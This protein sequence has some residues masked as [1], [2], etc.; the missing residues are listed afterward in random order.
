MTQAEFNDFMATWLTENGGTY[1]S[2]HTGQEIDSAIAAV[3]GKAN[4][5]H[6]HATTDINS[7][8]L[9][10]ARGGTGQ[11]TL[12]LGSFLVGNG[13]NGIAATTPVDATLQMGRGYGNSST[14][15]ATL[16]KVVTLPGFMRNTG[17][18]VGVRH[19]YANTAFSPVMNVN[20]TGSAPIRDCRTGA[21]PDVGAMG[22]GAHFYQFDGMAW[23]L[24][25]P[26]IATPPSPLIEK[27][28][29]TVTTVNMA[30]MNIPLSSLANYSRLEISMR[31]FTTGNNGGNVLLGVGG[32][33]SG[34]YQRST[35]ATA[36]AN[37]NNIGAVRAAPFTALNTQSS[38]CILHLSPGVG[39]GRASI[40]ADVAGFALYGST[41][42]FDWSLG[43]VQV[44][45]MADVTTFDLRPQTDQLAA[46]CEI[47]VY[48]VRR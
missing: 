27:I 37:S 29:E 38:R 42:W 20:S 26:I 24:L 22:A 39:N 5:A 9:S 44:N 8:S 40:M 3:P 11:S 13:T 46:G 32:I 43:G 31:L 21:P 4:A 18:V 10:V 23:M 6:T 2:A 14:P 36:A 45:T 16:T 47:I 17:A 34:Y 48:G 15:A 35:V 30:R 1:N 12:T 7:G 19:I 28:Y 41:P 25:N 33:E